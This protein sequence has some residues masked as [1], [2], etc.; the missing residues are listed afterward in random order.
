MTTLNTVGASNG[1][2]DP[3]GV[4]RPSQSLSIA[5]R[6][7]SNASSAKVVGVELSAQALALYQSKIVSAGAV[8]TYTAAQALSLGGAAADGSIAIVDTSANLAKNFNAL[9]ALNDKIGAIS[10]KDVKALA[11]TE[12]QFMAGTALLSKINSGGYSVAVTGVHAS[13]LKSLATYGAKIAAITVADTS[14]QI[15]ANLADISALGTK[16]T[17]LA[18]TTKSAMALAY[19]DVVKYANVLSRVDKG[20]YSLN[21]TDEAKNL[22]TNLVAV[23]KLGSKIAAITQT[24]VS[25]A[26][27]MSVS[28]FT[29][30]L[31]TLKKIN[32]GNFQF[33]LEDTG[34]A[35]I[36]AWSAV[37][38]VKGNLRALKLTD[39]VPSL[40]L[41]AAQVKSGTD[42]ISK[43]SNDSYVL[44][45]SDTAANITS[46]LSDL[47]SAGGAIAKVTQTDKADITV[48]ADQL[49][50]AG[51][52]TFLGKFGAASYG[53]SV[54][55]ATKSNVVSVLGNTHVK[56]I[57]LQI[58]DG[59]LGSSDAA[60]SA[61][62]GDVKITSIAIE[63]VA[64]ANLS[65]IAAD[66][67]V[68]S[69][70]VR[71]TSENLTNA[72]NLVAIDGLMKKRKGLITAVN[73]NSDTHD[74]IQIDSATYSKYASTIYSARKNY[75]LQ[76]D[77]SAS[78]AGLSLTDEQL[79]NAFKTT[80]NVNGS[81][82]VQMWDF[83]KGG[84]QKAMTFNAGVN[85]LKVGSVSTFLDSGDAKLNAVL[86]V[87]SF[88]WEQNPAQKTADTSSYEIKPGVFALKDGAAKQVIKY[89]FLS[90]ASDPA[91]STALDQKGFKA[92]SAD[93]MASVTK[94]LNYISSLVNIQFDLISSGSADINFGMND[95][96][97]VS[98][99]YATGANPAMSSTKSVNLLLNKVTAVNNK[100]EQGDY[101]W[102]TLIHEVGHTLGLKH[103]GAYNAGGGGAAGPYLSPADDNRRNTVMSYYDPVDAKNWTN[104]SGTS[105]SYASVNPRTYMPLDILALQFLYGKNTTGT[106]LTDSNKTLDVFQTTTFNANWMGMETLSSTVDG[107]SVDLSGVQ[108]SNIV[109]LRAGAFSSI[110]IKD[111]TYNAQLGSA[112]TLQTFYNLN[113]VG[114]SYDAS[115]SSLI[116]GA[117]RDIVYV[118]NK[119]VEID[120]GAGVD[121]VYL[122]GSASEWTQ[123]QSDDETRYTNGAVTATL[124]GIEAVAY[125]DMSSTAVM[126]SRVDLTA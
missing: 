69:I 42:L 123:T 117:G 51:L 106:S 68:K 96:G 27:K 32:G 16:V 103:P 26:M 34:A 17:A 48:S 105:Y 87:G 101:G 13:N 35:V 107:V 124:K 99:G 44:S 91:L 118:S 2:I 83:K 31:A 93:Q 20:A 1:V 126:H 73:L 109:D 5:S 55:G 86:N 56:S 62:L 108:A 30:S 41:T 98:G 100:P 97:T 64:I 19:S 37:S 72:T 22:K 7:L 70:G 3:Y 50:S 60:V 29:T 71:D 57:A 11:L 39:A 80:A 121:K 49:V 38:A 89:K 75:A 74:L 40:T 95:Q 33:E 46:N 53:L 10:Q 92:M 84:Y 12:A 78:V 88:Q 59:S 21:L 77:L 63:N 104:T 23:G 110:N 52:N 47:V 43:I 114:L 76:V 15:A 67:R 8:T 120:G 4:V 24:D 79:R 6:T 116:G 9:V 61:A 115:I 45:V 25:T 66:S 125:Y 122:Y 112:K 90:E 85:F 102:E 111:A 28:E 65:Q 54:T 58:S 81:F 18:Q 119:S 82:G 36:K 113:N 14:E 94:A